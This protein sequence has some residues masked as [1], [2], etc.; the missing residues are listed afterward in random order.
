MR[1]IDLIVGDGAAL[2]G[3]VKG[4]E[5]GAGPCLRGALDAGVIRRGGLVGHVRPL[6]SGPN[7][8]DAR[9]DNGW[10]TRVEIRPGDVVAGASPAIELC[11]TATLG[12]TM[13]E[14]RRRSHI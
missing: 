4:A 9:P 3:Q 6:G 11:I 2:R 14:P 1:E 13:T 10:L 8:I 12:P 7:G 5:Q